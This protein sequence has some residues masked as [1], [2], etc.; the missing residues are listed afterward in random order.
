MDVPALEM[1]KWFD[2]NY[3]Y[4]V[5]EIQ[6][7]RRSSSTRRSSRG[8]RGSEAL[9]HRAASGVVGPVTFLRLSKLAPGAGRATPRSTRSIACCRST[10]SCSRPRR[11]G[12]RLGPAR[13][14]VPGARSRRPHPRGA[15]GA[16]YTGSTLHQS[17][18]KL[19]LTTYF[20]AAGRQPRSRGGLRLR[21]AC[22]SISF[23][24][25]SSSRRSSAGLGR[26]MT[27][28][29]GVVDGRNIWR[30]DLDRR[31]LVV[32]KRRAGARRDRVWSPLVLAPARPRRSRPQR[33]SSTP[34]SSLA[35]LRG[36]EAR[37]VVGARRRRRRAQQPT[38]PL[39]D[40]RG[41]HSPRA[42]ARRASPRTRQSAPR[43]RS[44][45]SDTVDAAV[46]LTPSARARSARASSSRRSRPRRSARSRRPATS[47]RRARLRRAASS[48]AR[49]LRR[50]S[51]RRRS[52]KCVER[53]GGAGARR[54]RAR[55]VRAQR[56]G[57]ILRRAARRLRLHAR[58][59]GCRATARAA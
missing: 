48:D 31:T 14:A 38:E 52:R 35:G 34:S 4:I 28:S 30:T 8:D 20:G 57:R 12:R 56:H 21:R 27:L 53:A 2:T 1:T 54:A 11:A 7:G 17:R 29:L 16:A 46:R 19:L 33:R 58:T 24:R 6:P 13:R 23:A 50:S 49:R 5:P 44:V 55:R 39:F 10:K 40:R 18:P 25:P 36:A 22:T 26:H 3:H 32:E 47:A 42:E 37:R 45:T 9:G 59:A 41:A 43:A 51:S 15:I